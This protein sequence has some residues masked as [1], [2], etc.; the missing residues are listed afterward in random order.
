MEG[1]M[2]RRKMVMML[3]LKDEVVMSMNGGM[4]ILGAGIGPNQG[5]PGPRDLGDPQTSSLQ[6]IGM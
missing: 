2:K 1:L 3:M 4:K 6:L 5:A